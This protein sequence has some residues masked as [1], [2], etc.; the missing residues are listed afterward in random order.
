M[1]WRMK[2]YPWKQHLKPDEDGIKMPGSFY[3][4]VIKI[5]KSGYLHNGGMKNDKNQQ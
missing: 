3:G 5:V 2:D 1:I 4:E